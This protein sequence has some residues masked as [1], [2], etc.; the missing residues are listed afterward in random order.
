MLVVVYNK[1]RKRRLKQTRRVLSSIL[2]PI[3]KRLHIGDIPSRNIIDLIKKLKES[4]GIGLNIKFFIESKEGYKGF[5][6]ISLGK[7]NELLEQFEISS[8]KIDEK[9][10]K[11]KI[12]KSDPYKK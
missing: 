5:K 1:S 2:F 8:S 11:N 3:E 10:I 4:S 7:K 12:I 6:L 9:L